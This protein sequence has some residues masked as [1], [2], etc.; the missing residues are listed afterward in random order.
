MLGTPGMGRPRAGAGS[1]R[2]APQLEQVVQPRGVRS[3]AVRFGHPQQRR[4]G[5]TFEGRYSI[6]DDSNTGGH[7]RAESDLSIGEIGC[8]SDRRACSSSEMGSYTGE[9]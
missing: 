1:V 8:D 6:L 7:D 2:G 3:G 9:R 4:A 5:P